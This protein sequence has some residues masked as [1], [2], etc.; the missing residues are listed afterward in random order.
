MSMEYDQLL[1]KHRTNVR[2]AYFWIK[3]SLPELL[4]D[5]PG[6][7]YSWYIDFHDDSKTIP[8]EYQAVDNYLFGEWSPEVEQRYIRSK[9]E[10]R[11]RNPHHWQYWILHNDDGTTT[12]LDMEYPY[13]IEMICDWW[14][15]SWE[16]NDLFQIFDW[17]DKHKKQIKF[18]RN[19]RKTVED[20][21]RKLKEKIIKVRG[22]RK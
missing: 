14:S 18:S 22:P 16:Q 15:F 21:L 5:L 7:D 6:V 8:D 1:K 3:K 4:V 11:H 20:I 9:L 2:K 19:T 13:I 10:H 12:I 17:Y